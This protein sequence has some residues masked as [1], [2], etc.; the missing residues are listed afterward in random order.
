MQQNN[1]EISELVLSTKSSSLLD[2]DIFSESCFL[3]AALH[4][5]K[6]ANFSLDLM[7]NHLSLLEHAFHT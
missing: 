1:D 4:R 2:L 5:N 6:F 7:Q 3:P